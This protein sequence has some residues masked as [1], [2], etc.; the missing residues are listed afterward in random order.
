MNHKF[1]HDDQHNGD[2]NDLSEKLKF[3]EP[4]F[5][6]ENIILEN[7]LC[8]HCGPQRSPRYCFKPLSAAGLLLKVN[9]SQRILGLSIP[10]TTA[11]TQR[12]PRAAMVAKKTWKS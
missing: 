4:Y 5:H 11:V 8:V 9:L 2:K 10:G 7:L 3:V 12:T 6:K 1:N